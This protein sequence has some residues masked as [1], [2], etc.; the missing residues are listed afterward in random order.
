[1]SA[2]S[3]SLISKFTCVALGSDDGDRDSVDCG[4][5][6][7]GLYVGGLSAAKRFGNI[8]GGKVEY[9]CTVAARIAR[10]V[11]ISG[12]GKKHVVAE[13]DDH[14]MADILVVLEP[15]LT[16]MDEAVEQN[17]GCLVHCASGISRSVTAC[18]AWLMTRKGRSLDDALREIRAVRPHANPNFGFKIALQALEKCKGDFVKARELWK[19]N[20]NGKNAW[21]RVLSLREAAN[22]LHF[23]AD[24]L[25]ERLASE[26]R[27]PELKAQLMELQRK[28]S[29]KASQSLD[30]R[31]ALTVRKAA[32]QKIKRL[33]EAFS[34]DK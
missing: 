28:A 15:I 34:R 26:D 30:D 11:D 24:V 1:M 14:P 3:S 13:I 8:A 29:K 23:E 21:S 17:K 5:F 2:V 33:L 27:S 16:C 6:Y 18:A 19:H 31:V 10:E 20:W 32:M 7:D 12:C 4:E 22:A 9:V 25:E